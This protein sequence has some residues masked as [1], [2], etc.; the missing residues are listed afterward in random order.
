[1]HPAT[2]RSVIDGLDPSSLLD[3]FCGSG[4]TLIEAIRH[5]ATSHGYDANPFAVR[6]AS[7]K[8]WLPGR[9]LI[10]ELSVV[11]RQ[12]ADACIE[13]VKAARRGKGTRSAEKRRDPE[14]RPKVRKGLRGQFPPHILAELENIAAHIRDDADDV[15]ALHLEMILTSILYKVSL[16]KSDTDA[17]IIR[18]QVPRAAASRH[19]RDRVVSYSDSLRGLDRLAGPAPEIALADARSLDL[20][21]NSV[22]LVLTSPPY[23]GTYNY[24]DHHRLRMDFLGMETRTFEKSELGARRN[25]RG[26]A[27]VVQRSMKAWR[28]DTVGVLKQMRASLRPDGFLCLLVGD[29]LA[30][31]LAVRAN[32]ELPTL[33]EGAGLAQIAWASQTR[34]PLG[35]REKQAFSPMPKREHLLL[36]GQKR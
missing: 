34:N 13:E 33:A 14:S 19:F 6:L 22:D 8:T 21:P 12:I 32:Q 17:T 23:P 30:G 9:K 25:F 11:G 35:S 1:M 2:A 24:V 10:K 20:R 28:E 36:F 16:R 15:V 31:N 29:S 26:P 18:R 3:P 5:R 4:T 27:A 7:A